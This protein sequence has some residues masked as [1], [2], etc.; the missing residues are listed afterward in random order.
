[1]KSEYEPLCSTK[2]C[3]TRVHT[4]FINGHKFVSKSFIDTHNKPVAAHIKNY[5][6]HWRFDD[7]GIVIGYW[8]DIITR[9]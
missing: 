3:Y 2:T 1:M 9:I 6:E 7:N 8:N 5:R 4:K